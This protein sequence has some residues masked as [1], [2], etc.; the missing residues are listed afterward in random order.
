M[1]KKSIYI[2]VIIVFLTGY[3]S[4]KSLSKQESL[5][6]EKLNNG[7][8]NMIKK[9]E[10][11]N[12]EW[13]EVLTPEKYRVMRKSGT[14]KP[15]SGKYDNHY[16]K[17]IYYCAGCNTPLFSSET[18]YDHGT[19]W[20][21][22]KAPFDENYIEYRKDNSL[23]MRRIEVRCAVCGA[24]LGHVFDDGPG[25]T[26]KHYCINSVSLD[27]KEAELKPKSGS[28]H[29]E[30]SDDSAKKVAK[31]QEAIFAAGCFWGVEDKFRKIPGVVSTEVGYT[32]G[33][34]KN[35]TYEQ[36][37]TDKTGH[38]EAVK[39]TFDPS[40]ISYEGLLKVFFSIH[41]A[42]QIN[43][44]GPDI[45]RQ[46]R[47]AIFYFNDEQKM[48]AEKIIKELES[49]GRF[50]KS[51][52]TEIVPASEFNKAERYHQ[53]YYEKRKKGNN[54]QCGTDSCLI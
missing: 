35:P 50:G 43:R 4:L 47:S 30:K 45:G 21:S 6:T 3:L 7:E 19:G 10:K 36:V 38:A 5:N 41:D 20:P 8:N 18:K 32:G 17:G 12:K 40:L 15:F 34:V 1:K 52:A 9:V 31:T 33:R 39:I 25:P 53:Q 2:I 46:Y 37:C 51:I 16:E 23:F 24:H 11:T 26:H 49:S 42:T 54:G 14:E 44:Q 29:S 22:F 27:F 48:A 28:N 13:K